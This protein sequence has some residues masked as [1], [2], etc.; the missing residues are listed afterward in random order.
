MSA[1]AVCIIMTVLSLVSWTGTRAQAERD[2]RTRTEQEDERAVAERFFRAGEQAY[3]AGQYLMAAQAFE[4]AYERAPLPAIAFST[5]QAYRLQYFIDKEPSW[6]V[7][8]IEL[9]RLYI[10]E[11][12]RGGRREDAS[13]S[14]A[15]LEPIRIRLEAQGR[16]RGVA[17]ARSRAGG[18]QLMITSQVAGARAFIDGKG[19]QVP[20]IRRVRPGTHEVT[21]T[22]DGYVSVTQQA[23]AVAGKFIVVEIDLEPKPGLLQ[24]ATEGGA[25]IALDGRPVGRA[26]VAQP[27]RAPAG[28]HFITISR[29]GRRPWS[30]EVELRRGEML[31]VRAELESTGQ[32][33]GAYWMF[34]VAGVLAGATGVSAGFAWLAD[35][36]LNILEQKRRTESLTLDELDTYRELEATRNQRIEW[37]YTFL[38]AGVAAAVTGG[39]LYWFDTPRVS[40]ATA[41]SASSSWTV[42]PALGPHQAGFAVAGS[43]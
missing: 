36:D 40:A 21:V 37:T 35:R 17:R 25:F 42:A 43:F 41:D 31:A 4:E 13:T 3:N 18:T 15:E 19:D 28:T 32:R 2:T 22:A 33:R 9:Y 26:P 23:T 34:G 8:A 1:R 27:L 12:P 20:L 11:V 14:L 29:R 24:V 7:R 38:G 5:A 6:L 10:E 39:I 16:L 30:R